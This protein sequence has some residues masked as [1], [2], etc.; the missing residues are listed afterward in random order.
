M[1]NTEFVQDNEIMI[2]KKKWICYSECVGRL[3]AAPFL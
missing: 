1:E 3:F 2:D